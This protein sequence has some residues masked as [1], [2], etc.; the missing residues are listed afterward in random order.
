MRIWLD[1]DGGKM[2]RIWEGDYFVY[3]SPITDIH[4]DIILV[5][6]KFHLNIL[7]FF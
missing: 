3:T 7:Y 5:W 4:K 2:K 1:K 6:I